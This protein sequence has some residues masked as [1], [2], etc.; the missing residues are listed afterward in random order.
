[1]SNLVQ[2]I[3]VRLRKGSSPSIRTKTKGPPGACAA[4]VPDVVEYIVD[5]ISDRLRA[6]PGYSSKLQPPLLTL[7]RHIDQ[8][9]DRVPGPVLCS[10]DSFS[11]DPK[12]NAFFVSP[13]HL[14][15]V[16]SESEEVRALFDADPSVPECWALLCMERK[17]REGPGM[18]LVGDYLR[19]DV[20]R[21]TVSF[22][23]H[24]LV[25]PGPNEA[26]ARGALKCCILDGLLNVLRQRIETAKQQT[27]DQ[28]SRL[29]VMRARLRRLDEQP[30]SQSRQ[31]RVGLQA[32]VANAESDLAHLDL[33]VETISDQLCYLISQLK[34][35][36]AL[37]SAE[38][39]PIHL[40]RLG[41]KLNQESEEPGYEIVL[42]EVRIA[43][44]TP[45]VGAL[46]QFPRGDLLPKVDFLRQAD[47]FLSQGRRPANP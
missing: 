18:A 33:V 19:R 42:F 31:S 7:L 34:H 36:D 44:Q 17:E 3:F 11:I 41:V 32:A 30:Q 29:Q 13:D 14:Q 24:Q 5:R 10:R 27:R 12:V 46:V 16:F 37:L 45:K 6:V 1:M 20:M 38:L 35:P 43:D 2:Q 23:E 26:D 8:M 28:T 40:S 22:G 25:A 9:V 4:T 39:T 15:K 21:T 47:L